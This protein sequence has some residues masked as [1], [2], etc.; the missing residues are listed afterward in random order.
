MEQGNSCNCDIGSNGGN[1]DN[2]DNSDNGGNGNSN[3]QLVV[4]FPKLLFISYL[5]NL[6]R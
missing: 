1:R 2:S 6:T 4:R 3:V 5:G